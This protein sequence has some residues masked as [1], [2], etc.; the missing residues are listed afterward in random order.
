MELRS[1]NFLNSFICGI[2][3]ESIMS[4]RPSNFLNSSI[5]IVNGLGEL[6]TIKKL[7]NFQK[8]KMSVYFSTLS[9]KLK[10]YDIKI[11]N[12]DI[13]LLLF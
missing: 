5:T 6:I 12:D 4:L 10:V 2:V 13:Q 1:S 8:P 11:N 7:T 9:P 3:M